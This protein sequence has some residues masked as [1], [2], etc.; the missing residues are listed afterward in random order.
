MLP[1]A[2]SIPALVPSSLVPVRIESAVIA[3]HAEVN[4]AAWT[5]DVRSGLQSSV[6]MPM[7]P[8]PHIL[9]L[10]VGRSN[11]RCRL[12][13]LSPAWIDQLAPGAEMLVP[14]EHGLLHP[15]VQVRGASE[16]EGRFVGQSGFIPIRGLH[17][18]QRLCP[19]PETLPDTGTVEDLPEVLAQALP[20][21]D[22]SESH[23]RRAMWDL[24]TCYSRSTV[25]WSRPRRT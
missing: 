14:L 25:K 7:I 18:A 8:F 22:R 19:G 5:L 3:D 23:R 11:K 21:V 17:G 24:G 13:D 1:D 15:R 10:A 9:A 6:R 12:G 16:P 20:Q 4:P 2:K